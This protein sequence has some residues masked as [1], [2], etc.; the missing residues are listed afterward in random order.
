MH[1]YST[2]IYIHRYAYIYV[3]I[4]NS[5]SF[6]PN[7]RVTVCLCLY[8]CISDI[9]MCVYMSE[10]ICMSVCLSVCQSNLNCQSVYLSTASIC[11]PI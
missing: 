8:V 1:I 3:D 2:Y 7:L 10:S 9:G 11:L 6:C 5:L 4:S